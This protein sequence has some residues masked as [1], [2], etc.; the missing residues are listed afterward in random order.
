MPPYCTPMQSS[1][2]SRNTLLL[3]LLLRAK[4]SNILKFG[5]FFGLNLE[6]LDFDRFLMTFVCQWQ[7]RTLE[8]DTS[9]SNIPELIWLKL[10]VFLWFSTGANSHS[11]VSRTL[12]FLL[13]QY[14]KRLAITMANDPHIRF[15]HD[16]RIFLLQ[17]F[18]FLLEMTMF[19]TKN[20]DLSPK[21]I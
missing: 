18:L 2:R 9:S 14:W 8:V 10:F 7:K 17:I 16:S 15:I 21:S 4:I 1:I 3:L 11:I 13:Y 19:Q 6:I 20:I 12:P 5:R